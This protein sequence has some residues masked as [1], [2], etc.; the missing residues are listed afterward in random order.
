MAVTDPPVYPPQTGGDRD[1][2]I[3][4]AEKTPLVFGAWRGLKGLY[5]RVEGDAQ[6]DP[7]I[8]GALAARMDSSALLAASQV[9]KTLDLGNMGSLSGL[10]VSAAHLYALNNS[11]LAIFERGGPEPL[12]PRR[13]GFLR[14]SGGLHIVSAG[15]CLVVFTNVWARGVQTSEIHIVDVSNPEKPA[16]KS[17]LSWGASGQVA[18]HGS[19]VFVPVASENSKDFSGLRILSVANPDAPEIIGEVAIPNASG[20]FV[21]PDGWLAAVV[22]GGTSLNWRT[23]PKAAGVRLVEVQNPTRPRLIGSFDQNNVA[24]AAFASDTLYVSGQ[25]GF[26]AYDLSNP[27][28][29][30]KLGTWKNPTNAAVNTF[31]LKGNY[32]YV[33]PQWGQMSLVNISDPRK[34]TTE[35]TVGFASYYAPNKIVITG[36]DMYFV[37]SYGSGVEPWNLINPAKPARAGVPPSSETLAYMKRRARRLLRNLSKTDTR[38]FVELATELLCRDKV[39]DPARTWAA[40]D[41][42]YAGTNRYEQTRHGRGPYVLNKAQTGRLHL[43]TRDE[44]APQAWDARPDLLARIVENTDAPW[45]AQEMAARALRANRRPL[46]P[47]TNQGVLKRWL[48]SDS[49]LLV[50]LA[51]RAVSDG[52]AR[53][54]STDAALA[55]DVY[56][57]ANQT[58]RARIADALG[59]YNNKEWRK[60]F[61]KRLAELIPRQPNQGDGYTRRVLASAALLAERYSEEAGADS[62]LPLVPALLGTG[63]ADFATLIAAAARKVKPNELATWLRTLAPVPDNN[64]EPVLAALEDAFRNV[65]LEPR[66][67]SPLVLIPN[68]S[69]LYPLAW[70]IIA[71]SAT[72]QAPLNAIWTQLLNSTIETPML[73]AAMSSPYALGLL[74]RAGISIEEITEKLNS[75][76]FLVALLSPETFARLAQTAP[77]SVLLQLVAAMPDEQWEQVRNG[78]LRN[79]R[80]GVGLADLWA[81]LP[82]ALK[83]DTGRIETRIVQNA[84]FASALLGLEAEHV[85]TVLALRDPDAANLLRGWAERH[86]DAFARDSAP[87]L[88]AA[89]HP[90][91]PLR[92]WALTRVRSLGMGMPFALRLLESE[93]PSSVSVGQSFFNDEPTG[94]QQEFTYSLALCDSP[95]RSVRRYGREYVTKRWASLPHTEIERAL[96]ENPDPETQAFVARLLEGL[97]PVVPTYDDRSA[98]EK[99]AP[100]A[101]ASAPETTTN[102]IAAQEAAEFDRDVLRARNR[103]RAAKEAVKK[104]QETAQTLDVATLLELARGKGTPRDAEWALTQL[105][106]R[107]L[108][109]EQIEGFALEGVAGG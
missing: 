42:L 14:I 54:L 23:L 17:K 3:A 98:T 41:L 59:T 27:A 108:A 29:P 88:R 58:T 18:A 96:F 65:A 6:A 77:A 84:D 103:A 70:R 38:R 25:F 89:T 95:A 7:A 10:V 102:G 100:V 81:A 39:I 32:A 8:L 64:R 21:S 99:A 71:A 107:A 5:K 72:E 83:E 43:R 12:K 36:D 60:A 66:I 15:G 94:G 97:P 62:L 87:L 4:Y 34:L 63:R 68:P 20:V 48:V 11:Q 40:M 31:V 86:A 93:V 53:S 78:W 104:R 74:G 52:L 91:P 44:R 24:A 79:L 75:R 61:A 51:V 67:L 50:P 80:E 101:V 1:A 85:D 33:A 26:N 76:P 22:A 92:E 73:R 45:Q 55:A 46:P 82:G 57:R 13:L 105:A 28:R 19:N 2:L 49:A 37:P 90:L 106:R 16:V 69:E 35:G 30:Q 109:G 56:F 47:V 9:S